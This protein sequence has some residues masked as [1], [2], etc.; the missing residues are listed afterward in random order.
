MSKQKRGYRKANRGRGLSAKAAGKPRPSTPEAFPRYRVW[1]LPTRISHFL[2]AGLFVLLFVTG[3]FDWLPSVVHLWAG[4][5][6]LAVLLFRIHWGFF[7]AESARFSGFLAGPRAWMAYLPALLS[8]RPTLWAGHNPVGGL[9]V[10]TVLVLLLAL[11]VTGLFF[12]S[13]GEVRGPLAERVSRKLAIGLSDLHDVLRWPVL[14]LVIV[15]VAAT[16]GYRM[17]KSEDRIG[18]VFGDGRLELD[19]PPSLRFVPAA[20]ALWP[21]LSYLALTVLLVWLGRTI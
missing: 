7:G 4:Y 15:H 8:R 19:K 6:L 11:C 18:P 21:T 12:E 1:D 13:W 5:L 9:F 17:F 16:L 14:G 2:I 3:Q 10:V 20:R